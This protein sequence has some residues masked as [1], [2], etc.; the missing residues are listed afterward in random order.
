MLLIIQEKLVFLNSPYLHH[1]S[2]SK[3]ALDIDVFDTPLQGY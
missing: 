1:S 3:N 2:Y